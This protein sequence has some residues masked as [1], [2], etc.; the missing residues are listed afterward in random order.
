MYSQYRF[1]FP[2]P[3]LPL[4]SAMVSFA[5]QKLWCT[6]ASGSFNLS[7]LSSRMFSETY[8]SGLHCRSATQ[9][10]GPTVTLCIW[11]VVHLCKTEPSL[12]SGGSCISLHE[13]GWWGREGTAG[14]YTGPGKWQLGSPLVPLGSPVID[15]WLGLQYQVWITSYWMGQLD[16]CHSSP[17]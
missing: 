8:M 10:W 3:R 12:M 2:L 7:A 13:E 11:P 14:S 5:A 9:G 15:T 6:L 1:F 4:F 17:R 16:D